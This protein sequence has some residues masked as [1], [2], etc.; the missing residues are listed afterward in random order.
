VISQ[1]IARAVTE[2]LAP[3]VLVS[4]LLVLLAVHGAPSV[5]RGLVLG[6]VAALFESVLPFLY[7]LRGVRRGDL[8]DRHIGDH[9]QRRGPLLVGLASVTAGFVVL[10][11][12]DAQRELLAAV[13]AGGVGL[14]VAAVVNHW[15]KMSIHTAVASGAMVVLML[16]YGWP[17]VGTAPLV[18]AVG[19]SRVALK[20]HTPAQVVVGA[21]VGAAV[22]GGVFSALR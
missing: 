10:V 3:A 13:V 9:R 14:V 12:L 5:G 22:A 7:I 20:D 19:W 1:R 18:A 17:L 11:A 21:L 8:T 6:I 4:V 2:L 16:V 15:W